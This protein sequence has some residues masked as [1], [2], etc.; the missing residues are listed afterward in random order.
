[1]KEETVAGHRSTRQNGS[2]VVHWRRNAEMQ[3][4]LSLYS[5]AEIFEMNTLWLVV[6]GAAA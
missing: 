1:M 5:D 2:L 4:Y 3:Y 6:C